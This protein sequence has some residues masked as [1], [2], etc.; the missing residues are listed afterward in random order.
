MPRRA[1]TSA[2]AERDQ[3]R[4]RMRGL[5]CSI[6]QIAVEMGRRFGLRSRLAWRHALGWPQWK[7]AQQYNIVHPGASL[8]DHRVSEYE[9]WPHG[10]SPPSLRYLAR[11]AATYGH[12]CTPSQLVDA[13]DLEHLTPADRCLLTASPTGHATAAP[14]TTTPS[15]APCQRAHAPALPA[16][17]PDTGLVV[18]ADASGWVPAMGLALPD[19]LVMQLMTYLE[20]S[21]LSGRNALGTARDR[22]RAYHQLVGFLRSW[23]HNMD[24]RDALRLLSWATA[25]ASLALAID[26]DAHQRVAAML[27]TSNRVDAQT[28]EHIEEVLRCCTR[29]DAALGPQAVLNTVLAQRDLAR[30]LVPECPDALRPRLLSA[31]SEASRQA[32]W[33]S[34]DLRQFDNAGYYYEDAR[35]LAHEAQNIGLGAFVLCQ[36]SR[37]A[38][39]QGR[40]RLG[41]DH[42]VAAG[43]WANRIGDRRLQAMIADAAAR[44][45]AGE[46]QRDACLT[47]LDTSHAALTAATDHNPSHTPHYN[48]AF[49]ISFRGECHLALRESDRAV[50]YAQ[51]SLKTLDRS[52]TRTVAMTIVDLSEAYAQYTEIDEAARLLGDAGDIAARNS[53]ARLTERVKQS[54]AAL[55]PWKDTAAVRELD[56]RL[57][58]YSLA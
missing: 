18:V 49:H 25:A 40:P 31:L 29:Q 10:G 41:I 5:G 34:F 39:W 51:Q 32:G 48:E 55:Q 1:G 36:M 8:S 44:A 12:G 4:E 47:A 23:A 9:V 58:S 26:G 45:Y 17:Q 46:G 22:D 53:S 38:T 43:Q 27:G 14:I 54:R 37:L 15:P 24:R 3:L 13:D 28:I 16:G 21:G 7:L 52:R 11:L 50:F 2:K 30:V 20:S 19:A 6:P 35:V 56:D 33:L 42:A 57:A